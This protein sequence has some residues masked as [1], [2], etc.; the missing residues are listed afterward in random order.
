MMY[1]KKSGSARKIK[2][3]ALVPMLG[4]ALAAVALPPVSTAITTIGR[5]EVSIGKGSDN[6]P[7]QQNKTEKKSE[8][9]G[10][11]QTITTTTTNDGSNYKVTFSNNGEVKTL[12]LD[13]SMAED[14]VYYFLDFKQVPKSEITGVAADIIRSMSISKSDDVTI[15]QVATK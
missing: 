5:S 11:W 6:N 7:D 12:T 13:K 15:I 14:G 8:P 4:L 3:L 1:K 10:E 2:A 9:K